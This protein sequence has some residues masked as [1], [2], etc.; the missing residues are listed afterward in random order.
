MNYLCTVLLF[1]DN[2]NVLNLHEKH[3]GPILVLLA[4]KKV[5]SNLFV[6]FFII[7]SR[8]VK[9]SF[10]TSFFEFLYF[11]LQITVFCLKFF[12]YYKLDG[13]C[14]VLFVCE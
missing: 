6:S 11:I 13:N 4:L 9:F 5:L 1:T 10:E 8:D 7:K 12:M 14:L 3:R 2:V